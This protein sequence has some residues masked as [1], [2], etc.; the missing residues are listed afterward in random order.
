MAMMV[1]QNATCAEVAADLAREGTLNLINDVDMAAVA[2]MRNDESI[3]DV[4]QCIS[5]GEWEESE[6]FV[7]W[8]FDQGWWS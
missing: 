5:M 8:M 2:V 1:E 4:E 6:A 7:N 3:L